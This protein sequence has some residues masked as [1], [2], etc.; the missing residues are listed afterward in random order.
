[1]SNEEHQKILKIGFYAF[2]G[3]RI[4]IISVM[5]SPLIATIEAGGTKMIAGLASGPENIRVRERIPTTSPEET[6]SALISFLQS[7][8]SEHGG[9]AA[10]AIGSFGPLD[11]KLDSST[12]GFV[13]NTPK[14][15]WSNTDFLGPIQEALQVPAVFETDVNAALAGEAEWGAARGLQHAAYFT[16]GTGIGG[17]LM[18][19][20]NLIHG[21]GHSEM[22][23]M[24]VRRHADDYFEGCCPFH[25]DCLEG[26]ASGT[27]M[28]K[29]WGT[30]AEYLEKDHPAWEIEADYIAQ[31]CLN[32]LMIAPPQKIILGGGVMEQ[33]HLFP[34][35]LD[36]LKKHHNNYGTSPKW[37]GLVAP[38]ELGNNA[39]LLGCVALGQKILSGC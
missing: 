14:P 35:I 3:L 26:L 36:F 17:S 38:P 24:R 12:Y 13:T 21:E 10:L 31:A 1:M 19:D 2:C 16:I 28:N 8:S 22:G 5:S 23:H 32:L 4:G 33:E 6:I 34:M 11:L 27:A 18:I 20:G 39:G 7:A 30:N 9:P 29:R 15:G 37:D 25:Q